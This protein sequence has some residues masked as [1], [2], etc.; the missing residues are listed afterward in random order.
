VDLGWFFEPENLE[1][2]S[3]EELL[4]LLRVRQEIQKEK[5]GGL[6]RSNTRNFPPFFSLSDYRPDGA[7]CGLG[8]LPFRLLPP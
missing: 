3:D 4:W 2:L 7:T 6:S 8:F 1:K 5:R